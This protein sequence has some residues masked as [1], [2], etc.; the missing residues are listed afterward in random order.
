M[1]FEYFIKIYNFFLGLSAWPGLARPQA[2]RGQ[3]RPDIPKNIN[4]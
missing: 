2:G 3:I 1:I 4:F